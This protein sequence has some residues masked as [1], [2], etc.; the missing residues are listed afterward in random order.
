M[1]KTS[2]S[3]QYKILFLKVDESSN[4]CYNILVLGRLLI[5]RVHKKPTKQTK[6]VIEI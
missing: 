5:F 4:R 2:H 3:R 6:I 1:K